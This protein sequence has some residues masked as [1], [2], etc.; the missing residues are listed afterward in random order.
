[1]NFNLASTPNIIFG[2]NKFK[3]LPQLV[4]QFGNK[5]IIIT[6]KSSF[7]QSHLAIELF[8]DLDFLKIQTEIVTI[9]EEPT[10]QL[11]D[12]AIAKYKVW[13]PHVVVAI[14][15]GSVMDAG[16]AISAMLRE[17]GSIIEY[18]EGVGTKL[19]SGEKTPLIAVPT[20][21]GTGSETTKNA[22][23]TKPGSDGFKKSLR[24]NNYVPNIALV[25]PQ[26]TIAC[27]PAVTAASGMDTFTQL[28]ESYVS[29]NGNPISNALAFDGLIK[30]ISSLEKAVKNG[31]NLQARSNMSYAAMV[32]GITLANAGLGVVHGFAQPLGSSFE[33]P[34]GIVCGTLMGAT[35][36]I[37]VKRL[38]EEDNQKTLDKYY[39]VAQL[40]STKNNR[41]EVIDD[42]IQYLNNLT[43][44]FNLPKLSSFGINET[45]F[46]S[47][48]QKT[49]LKNHPIQ[50]SNK[51]LRWILEQRT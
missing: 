51:D 34:H 14:G 25:D 18:L 41:N 2:L 30:I 39:M 43:I 5:A 8:Q 26:L 40:I 9:A 48:I 17:D 16:K 23:I 13:N 7:M 38:R 45:H 27:P 29:T 28:L 44:K 47:I 15:G 32:S 33:V 24:H 4:E 21:S 1:M 31:N 3:Q 11:I 6:G 42:F 19:P 49:G 12:E 50:L 36:E 22:V 10:P 35:N 20:T 46:N 37:T